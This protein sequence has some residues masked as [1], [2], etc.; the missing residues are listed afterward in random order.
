MITDK[1]SK[2]LAWFIAIV[3]ALFGVAS[4]A[5][6][7]QGNRTYQ[8]SAGV[9]DLNKIET[10]LKFIYKNDVM[11]HAV[12]RP[13]NPVSYLRSGSNY[14]LAFKLKNATAH[15]G[16]I[17]ADCFVQIDDRT[18]QFTLA[19]CYNA[20]TEEELRGGQMD[21]SSIRGR[22]T[23]FEGLDLSQLEDE[24]ADRIDGQIF[25]FD[26]KYKSKQS[27]SGIYTTKALRTD[28]SEVACKIVVSSTTKSALVTCLDSN[29][30]IL[31]EFNMSADAL[32]LGDK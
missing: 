9:V 23:H 25:K 19:P 31:T 26:K 18:K 12:R 22:L 21:Y 8:T 15:G 16:D 7:D 1:G 28:G 5:K 6:A 30:Q 29:D 14:I 17:E 32:G 27:I 3:V 4:M 24:L 20:I 2:L 13:W 11:V 10:Q